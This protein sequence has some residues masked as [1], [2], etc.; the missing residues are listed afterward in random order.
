MAT[1]QPPVWELAWSY[2]KDRG[3]KGRE[4]QSENERGA[5]CNG[6][7]GCTATLTASKQ[8]YVQYWLRVWQVQSK[9]S[10][11]RKGAFHRGLEEILLLPDGPSEATPGRL[12]LMSLKGNLD[13]YLHGR[14]DNRLYSLG[15]RSSLLK[16]RGAPFMPP[17]NSNSD[18]KKKI[19]F[20][21]VINNNAFGPGN[22]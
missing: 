21:H 7:L 13:F 9:S 15:S 1:S 19:T 8:D 16:R 11:W 3:Q 4:N 14:I 18:S 12:D 17:W 6:A 5:L 20:V 10:S 2:K 22:E